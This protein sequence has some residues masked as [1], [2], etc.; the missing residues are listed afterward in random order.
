[1]MTRSIRLSVS[2]AT[3]LLAACASTPTAPPPRAADT[4]LLAAPAMP[5]EAHVAKV[6]LETAAAPT[7]PIEPGIHMPD[8]TKTPGEPSYETIDQICTKGAATDA[9]NVS[10]A[11]KAKIYKSY[12]MEACKGICSGQQGC[13]I[14][15]LISL[16]IGGA[17]TEKNLWP[18]PYDGDW[19]A[20]DKDKLEGTLHKLVC[21][22][23]MTLEEAQD[24]IKTDWVAAY[25]K[26]VGARVPHTPYTYCKK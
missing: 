6:P 12:G 1:M 16:E 15:H 26:Y 8:P 17:N 24:A 25:K 13:E 23:T 4:T 5:V 18:Q 3:V 10:A 11:E 21:N 19:N 14:D 20:R 2:F 9:R 7:T 22:K